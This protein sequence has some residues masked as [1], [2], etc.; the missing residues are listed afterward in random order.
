[1][2]FWEADFGFAGV[3]LLKKQNNLGGEWDGIHVIEVNEKK[4]VINLKLFTIFR[5]SMKELSKY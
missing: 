5:K 4:L 1:V 3:V 2:Y